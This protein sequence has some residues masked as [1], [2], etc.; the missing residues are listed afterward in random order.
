MNTLGL[1]GL[2]EDVSGWIEGD[3]TREKVV[4]ALQARGIP[5]PEGTEQPKPEEVQ[6]PSA[7]SVGQQV[8]DAAAGKDTRNLDE[9]LAQ[10]DS[11]EEL[12]A[13]MEEAALTRSHS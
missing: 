4:E 12:N 1:P 7:S 9:K 8:A 2:S 10:A 5:L 6:K 3:A 11:Q 13:L